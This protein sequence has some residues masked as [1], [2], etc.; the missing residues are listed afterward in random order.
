MLGVISKDKKVLMFC[1]ILKKK[2]KIRIQPTY[3]VLN[4]FSNSETNAISQIFKMRHCLD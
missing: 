4:I 2:E 1:K 3:T